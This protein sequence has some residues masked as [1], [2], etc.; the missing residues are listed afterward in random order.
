MS[1]FDDECAPTLLPEEAS[2]AGVAPEPTDPL[3][4]PRAPA[5][6][7]EASALSPV[8][9]R[10]RR[11]SRKRLLL[12]VVL[13]VVLTS[14]GVG[15]RQLWITIHLPPQLAVSTFTIPFVPPY[16][17][18]AFHPE[19]N[20][21]ME[22]LHLITGPDG[23]LYFLPDFGNWIGRM[24]PDGRASRI[25]LPPLD[26]SISFLSWTGLSQGGGSIWAS[27][28][29]GGLWR[30]DL[31]SGN[32]IAYGRNDAQHE[33][34]NGIGI[35]D[36]SVWLEEV[37][38]RGLFNDHL[39]ALKH[40]HPQTG[41]L[42][43]FPI[44][45]TSNAW[46]PLVQ[47]TDGSLWIITAQ[48][49]A[50]AGITTSI[51]VN[52]FDPQTGTA[53]SFPI[54]PTFPKFE[55]TSIPL[56][57]PDVTYPPAVMAGPPVADSPMLTPAADGGVWV[58]C[59]GHAADGF[60]SYPVHISPTGRQTV[61]LA[62][63]GGSV[64]AMLPDTK[65]ILW[66]VYYDPTISPHFLLGQLSASGSITPVGRLTDSQPRYLAVGAGQH[67]YM[68]TAWSSNTLERVDLSALGADSSPP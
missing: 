32:M 35:Q 5:L 34:W 60:I 51:G 25:P 3:A 59:E 10:A 14:L 55:S 54:A 46:G 15:G 26:P 50:A 37:D 45:L 30:L 56:Q 36:G 11:F 17:P 47:A 4:V 66:V 31:A 48:L 20:P 23:N 33:W 62:P 1:P 44:T 28:Q 67:L 2:S 64:V 57:F 41:Q 6:S 42:D 43:T 27:E 63:D 19:T 65:T 7:S 8:S 21:T 9:A 53:T 24:T 40:F 39:L 16:E 29:W 38:D 68:T 52:H 58:L 12:G 22:L 49:N 18:T 61:A 13:L